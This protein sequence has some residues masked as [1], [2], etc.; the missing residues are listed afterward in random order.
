MG[1]GGCARQVKLPLASL[2]AIRHNIESCLRTLPTFL[3]ALIRV[4]PFMT[5]AQAQIYYPMSFLATHVNW[6]LS[7]KLQEHL[8]LAHLRQRSL[9]SEVREIWRSPPPC[10]SISPFVLISSQY[11]QLIHKTCQIRIF[12]PERRIAYSRGCNLA[13]ILRRLPRLLQASILICTC[14]NS[15]LTA[16]LKQARVAALQILALSETSKRAL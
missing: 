15:G 8:S 10:R 2:G 16:K 5:Q 9:T 11:L 12:S 14:S 1:K 6:N 13:A 7:T 3:Q 4:E